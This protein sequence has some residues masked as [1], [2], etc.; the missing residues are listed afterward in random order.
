MNLDELIN[1]LLANRGLSSAVDIQEF[2]HP[3]SPTDI[4]LSS[5]GLDPDSVQQAIQ[6]IKHH[7]E[8]KNP[9]AVYGDYDVD[10]LCSTAILW[11]TLYHKTLS[12]FV[13]PYI[14]HRKSEGYGLSQAGIDACLSKGAKL[15]ITVDNGI[16]AH[17]QISYARAQ[18]ADVIVIDHH[19]PETASNSPSSLP[20]ANVILHST[21][22]C[23]AGLT[24]FF[25]RE[26]SRVASGQRLAANGHLSLVSLAVVCDMVPL[27]GINRSLV[28][29]GLEEIRCTSRPGLLSLLKDSAVSPEDIEAYHLGFVIGPRLNA[30]GRLE[31]AL[32]SL[33]LLCTHDPSQADELAAK[34]GET[35]RSRQQ[36]T[37]DATAHAISQI[38]T[39]YGANLPKLLI[40]A[41]PSYDE[42]VVGL[43][44]AKLLEKYSRPSI[45]LSV[46]P[47]F[48]KASARSVPGFHI[49]EHLRRSSHL[50]AA[51]GGHAMAAGFSVK[52]SDLEQ[53][54]ELLV[55]DAQGQVNDS[56]LVKTRRVDAEIPFSL[57]GFDLYNR[58]QDFAPFG[59]GNPQPVFFT[60]SLSISNPRRLGKQNQH[61][62]FQV[63]QFDAIAFNFSANPPAVAGLYY[64]LDTNTWNGQTKLQLII[65]DIV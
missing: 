31:H 28:K 12:P 26:F 63:N 55:S 34:L 54:I 36:L 7:Q 40:V 58:L 35:N 50:L 13:F 15:I 41:D 51:V 27:L 46:G 10:G 4:P 61:L 45:A 65:K 37:I 22:T 64:S 24:W 39:K 62:K 14:P 20:P 8:N 1:I 33:R 48:S 2:F 53:L 18:G 23:A 30:M 43:V 17:S 59:L 29:A 19:E 52:T 38:E 44:A 57:V 11:E 16:V 3:Q 47:E 42:G 49:T 25:S 56:L 32:D 9:I 21:K 60:P 6:L 5:S